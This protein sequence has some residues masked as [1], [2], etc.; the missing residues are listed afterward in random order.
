MSNHIALVIVGGGGQNVCKYSAHL[1][2]SC[3]AGPHAVARHAQHA[4][5][6][7]TVHD[8]RR[9]AGAHHGCNVSPL[10]LRCKAC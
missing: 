2:S 4:C 7:F 8:A 3:N 10:L 1:F 6:G 9:A 5:V